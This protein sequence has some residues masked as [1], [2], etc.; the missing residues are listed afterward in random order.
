MT[1]LFN[2]QF[3]ESYKIFFSWDADVRPKPEIH[4][5]SDFKNFESSRM[6]YGLRR[7]GEVRLRRL[8]RVRFLLFKPRLI[9]QRYTER[10]RLAP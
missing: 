9:H 7:V 3:P 1:T 8:H 10:H 5:I 6:R 2:F 4:P